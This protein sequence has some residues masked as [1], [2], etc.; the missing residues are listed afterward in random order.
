[1]RKDAIQFSRI[2]T[3]PGS[4]N[5]FGSGD[6]H[7]YAQQVTDFVLK[8]EAYLLQADNERLKHDIAVAASKEI[9]TDFE[10]FKNALLETDP[11]KVL[12]NVGS[13][14]IATQGTDLF[15]QASDLSVHWLEQSGTMSYRRIFAQHPEQARQ[16]IQQ[17]RDL[18]VRHQSVLPEP[19]QDSYKFSCENLQVSLKRQSRPSW[20][21]ATTSILTDS[22][23]PKPLG[24]NSKDG[25]TRNSTEEGLHETWVHNVGCVDF[26]LG[27]SRRGSADRCDYRCRSVQIYAPQRPNE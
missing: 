23:S 20:T 14:L 15:Q 7:E 24:K 22:D 4:R 1:M 17:T 27:C 21:T 8:T 26:S 12:S 3:A 11:V 19:F 5:R 10:R 9:E 25:S 18:L 13:I 6:H 2:A 16:T